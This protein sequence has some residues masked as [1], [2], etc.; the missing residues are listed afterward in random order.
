MQACNTRIYRWRQEKQA[1]KVIFGYVA[2]SMIPCTTLRL[3]L[4]RKGRGGGDLPDDLYLWILPACRKEIRAKILK[5]HLKKS[6]QTRWQHLLWVGCVFLP[7]APQRWSLA[8]P[9]VWCKEGEHKRRFRDIK[10]ESSRRPLGNCGLASI[11]STKHAFPCFP[12]RYSG[13]TLP[14]F[15]SY[16]GPAPV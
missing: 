1:V 11:L 5:L 13:A 3:C 2:T 7:V 16:C 14:P 4:K 12:S 10:T 6:T 15:R 9:T 8:T